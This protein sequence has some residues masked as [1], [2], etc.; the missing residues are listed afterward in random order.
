MNDKLTTLFNYLSKFVF[1]TQIKI[2]F[3]ERV[4]FLISLHVSIY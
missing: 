3:L 1:L 2:Q 4:F